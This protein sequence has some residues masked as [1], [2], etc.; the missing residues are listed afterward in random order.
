MAVTLANADKALKSVY[1]DVISD[2]IDKYSSPLLSR[3][4]KTTDS[5][6][7]KDVKKLVIHGANTG[8]GAGSEDGNLPKSSGNKYVQLTS[9]IKNLYGTIEISDKAIRASQHST[10]AF[11][12]LL[13]AEMEGLIKTSKL[14][15]ARMIY[16][17]GTGKLFNVLGI[18]NGKIYADN[19]TAVREGMI[20][21]VINDKTKEPVENGL[22]KTITHID[23][24][25][26]AVSLSGEAITFEENLVDSIIVCVQGSYNNEI[27]GLGAVMSNEMEEIY[28]LNKNAYSF[29]R[30]NRFHVYDILDDDKIETAIDEVERNSGNTINMIICSYSARRAFKRAMSKKRT[31]LDVQ[32][33]GYGYTGI[34]FDGIP[35]VVDRYCPD[36]EMYLIN[37]NDFELH[38]LC[39]WQWLEDDKGAILKQVPGKPVYTATLVKY[40]EL[41]CCNPS[42]QGCIYG[43]NNLPEENA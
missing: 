8:I 30:P 29:L 31:Y 1:L 12:N 19:I 24:T 40:A 26:G 17:N 23:K 38:Q 2:Q 18:D 28:G 5:V 22:G 3:I 7:G 32:N 33:F 20:V 15:F 34:N 9:S 25:F 27:T 13:N 39:D 36:D 41:I 37:T 4:K 35:M 6:Y 43:V 10:N 42:G 11:V 21:D 16:G 14:N